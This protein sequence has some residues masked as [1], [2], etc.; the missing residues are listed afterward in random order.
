[1]I[2]VFLGSLDVVRFAQ[3][4]PGELQLPIAVREE[5]ELFLR[6]SCPAYLPM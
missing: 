4:Q 3:L 2:V 6:R 5:V 1:M